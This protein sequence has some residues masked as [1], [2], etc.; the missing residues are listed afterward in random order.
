MLYL[1][2]QITSS[3]DVLQ[4]MTE[5]ELLAMLQQPQPEICSMI[6]QLRIYGV[7]KEKYNGRNESGCK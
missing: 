6:E 4:P 2:K 7:K 5:E 1:G 3:A